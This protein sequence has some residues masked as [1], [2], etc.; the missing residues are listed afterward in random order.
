MAGGALVPRAPAP[1]LLERGGL[2]ITDNILS[3]R[4]AILNRVDWLETIFWIAVG[5]A[6][7]IKIKIISFVI[8]HDRIIVGTAVLHIVINVVML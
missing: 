1:L 6:F 5:P 2:N 7:F 3:N 4:L 8:R